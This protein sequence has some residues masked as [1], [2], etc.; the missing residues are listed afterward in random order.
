MTYA[1]SR[2][3]ADEP[4]PLVPN[5]SACPE[6]EIMT[7]GGCVP[8]KELF[9]HLPPPCDD[10]EKIRDMFRKVGIEPAMPDSSYDKK[11]SAM[12]A[13]LRWCQEN[14]ID[15]SDDQAVC[16]AL[17]EESE[18]AEAGVSTGAIVAIAAVGVLVVGGAFYLSRRRS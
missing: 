18:K 11:Q 7:A 1:L 3:G 9:A 16:D 8:E 5:G 10:P 2:F 15:C 14:S 12:I 4:A 17:V 6:G 13:V